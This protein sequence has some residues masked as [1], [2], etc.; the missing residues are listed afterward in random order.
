MQWRNIGCTVW[1]QSGFLEKENTCLLNYET[2]SLKYTYRNWRSKHCS[3]CKSW[4][5]GGAI[6]N[7]AGGINLL[8]VKKYGQA[9]KAGGG[10]FDSNNGI[11]Y[12][13]TDGSI[14]TSE[15][16]FQI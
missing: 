10:Y 2:K 1:G 6:Y 13:E 5:G 8:T 9:V 12:P 3:E 14:M 4:R 16:F 7:A 15:L 11:D